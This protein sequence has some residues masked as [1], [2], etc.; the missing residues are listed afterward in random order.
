MKKIVLLFGGFILL[1]S[2]CAPEDP[3]PV[4]PGV[5]SLISPANN[6]TCLDGTSLNDTQSNVHFSW[7]SAQDALSYE[8]VVTN[9]LTQSSQTYT[10]AANQT[11]IALTKAEPY[12]WRVKSIG[13]VGSTPAESELWK[14]YLAGDAVVNYAPFPTELI[15]PRSG[16][17]ITPDVNN[18]VTLNW[19][20]SDVDEDLTRYEVYLD[21]T[22]ATTLISTLDFEANDT[23]LEVEVENN[24]T[25]YWKIIA[26]DANGNQSNS[27]VYAFERID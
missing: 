21:Q 8:V 20:G 24:T 12:S 14:F 2:S 3:I 11:T 17:N 5:A 10:A 15:S 16:T 4:E 18:L 13:E 26:F 27:G 6:E 19:K 9:L 23:S 22:N 7:T 1:I 25:Y